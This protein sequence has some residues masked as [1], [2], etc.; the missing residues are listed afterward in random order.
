M[1]EML[2]SSLILPAFGLGL[3]GYLVPRVLAL[4]LPEGVKALM[5]NGLLSTLLTYLAAS[6]LFVLLYQ[7]QGAELT[8]LT[9]TGWLEFVVFFGRLGLISALIWAP[10]MILSLAGLPKRWIHETW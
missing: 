5:L 2:N 9:T 7:S 4:L 8:V 1:D 3:L 10:I 6:A